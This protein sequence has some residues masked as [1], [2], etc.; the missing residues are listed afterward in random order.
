MHSEHEKLDVRFTW[1]HFESLP[2][3]IGF[4]LTIAHTPLYSKLNEARAYFHCSLS[5]HL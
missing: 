2:G 5:R 4:E 1:R 3:A